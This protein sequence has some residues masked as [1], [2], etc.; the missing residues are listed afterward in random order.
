[1]IDNTNSQHENLISAHAVSVPQQGGGYTPLDEALKSTGGS[2]TPPT[3]DGLQGATDI[4]KAI[5][6]AKDPAAAR[7]ALGAGTSSYTPPESVPAIP[8]LA[9]DANAAAIVA[10]YNKLLAAAR[11]SGIIA[12]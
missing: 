2:A 5:L 7:A 8:D 1:M 9:G 11:A 10:S 6:K 4:G 3:V 12:K